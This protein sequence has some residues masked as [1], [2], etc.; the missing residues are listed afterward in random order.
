MLGL[1][2]A[3]AVFVKIGLAPVLQFLQLKLGGVPSELG[4]AVTCRR[5]VDNSSWCARDLASFNGEGPTS[6]EPLSL[7]QEVKKSLQPYFK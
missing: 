3:K 5:W 1:Y 4:M 7:T 2:S 6:Q